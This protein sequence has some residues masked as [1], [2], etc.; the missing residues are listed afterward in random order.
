MR[1]IYLQLLH[2]AIYLTYSVLTYFYSKIAILIFLLMFLDFIF[3]NIITR[4]IKKVFFYL[5]NLVQI[6]LSYLIFYYIMYKTELW[7]YR[8][9][10][11]I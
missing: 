8:N 7:S 6:G 5:L 3:K 2:G 4:I 10:D 11:D 9:N 1:F